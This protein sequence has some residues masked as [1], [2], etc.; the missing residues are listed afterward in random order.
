MTFEVFFPS[1]WDGATVTE[2][3]FGH[4]FGWSCDLTADAGWCFRVKIPTLTP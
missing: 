3:L 4:Y 2:W 1:D